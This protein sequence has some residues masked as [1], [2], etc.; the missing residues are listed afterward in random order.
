MTVSAYRHHAAHT[1]HHQAR[2]QHAR[3]SHAATAHKGTVSNVRASDQAKINA[4]QGQSGFDSASASAKKLGTGN[5]SVDFN[6]TRHT[7]IEGSAANSKISLEKGFDANTQDGIA[8]TTTQ[9][10]QLGVKVGDT[11]HVRDNVT[12]ATYPATFHDSAGSGRRDQ[13]DHFEVS[14]T[15]ADKLGINYRTASGR[16]VDAVTNTES[17]KGRFSIEK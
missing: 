5:P 2:A 8:L 3:T 15:L 13:L 1:Y 12:G 6:G 16:V 4:Y 17:L 10:R 7:E 14:P 11:V 9:A